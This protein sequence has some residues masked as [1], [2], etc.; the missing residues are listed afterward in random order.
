MCVINYAKSFFYGTQNELKLNEYHICMHVKANS[1]L[2]NTL[3]SGH[4]D[5]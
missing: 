2:L 5:S 4:C 3:L 1:A